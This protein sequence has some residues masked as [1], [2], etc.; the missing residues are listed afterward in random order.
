MTK[1]CVCKMVRDKV[2]LTKWCVTMLCV[3][4]D[5]A[6][7]RKTKVD[8]AKCH[9]CHAKRRSI[10][11]CER[12]CVYKEVCERGCVTKRCVKEGV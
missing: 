11:W 3:T 8:V 1:L 12:W 6:N 4:R 9:A 5:R 7:P 2:V 10:R